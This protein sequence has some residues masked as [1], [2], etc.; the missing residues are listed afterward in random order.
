MTIR[1]GFTLVELL[2]VIAIIGILVALLLPAVQAAREAARRAQCVNNQKNLCLALVQSH[3]TFKKFPAGRKGCDGNLVFPECSSA[4]TDKNGAN[5]G[6]SGASAFARVL[7][8]I[9]EQALKDQ[10]HVDDIAIWGVNTSWFTTPEVAA[11]LGKRPAVFFCPS[12]GEMPLQ[13][14]YKHEV[15][16]GTEVA[17]GSYALNFGTKSTPETS[18]DVK[19][20]N[21]G[22]FIYVKQFKA[23]NITDGLTKTFFTGETTDGHLAVSSNI[24]SNGSRGN[25]LRTTGNPLNTPKGINQGGGYMKNAS[26]ATSPAGD[27]N[28]CFASRHPSGAN[29][30]F[31]DAHVTFIT[32]SIDF[33][34]YRALSTRAGDETINA[35]Y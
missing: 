30:G 20:N 13:A 23:S 33:D 27:N 9:E 35:D 25:L 34:A 28:T 15:P 1:R 12:D 7:P 22:I 17:A 3:E 26:T 32:D 4:G 29:F 18:N 10:L 19:F 24:W 2:V 21:T 6:Q 11:A 31:G 5:L 14:E 16:A 8:Y